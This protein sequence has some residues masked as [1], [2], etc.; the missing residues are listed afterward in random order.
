MELRYYNNPM[1]I[2]SVRSMVASNGQFHVQNLLNHKV[3]KA[4]GRKMQQIN[5]IRLTDHTTT[6]GFEMNKLNIQPSCPHL[7]IKTLVVKIKYSEQ[8]E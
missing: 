1:R 4:K 6:S 8:R 7:S 2:R 5:R 3:L